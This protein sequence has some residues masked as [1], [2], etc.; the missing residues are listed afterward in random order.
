MRKKQYKHIDTTQ[1][2]EDKIKT[3]LVI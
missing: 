1:N 2:K 3:K